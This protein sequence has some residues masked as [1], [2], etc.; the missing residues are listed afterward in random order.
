[1]ELSFKELICGL[2]YYLNQE[3]Q[4][5]D[6]HDLS[7]LWNE[8]VRLDK[9]TY[10]DE[11][12]YEKLFEPVEKLMKEFNDI[13][14]KSMAFRYPVGK[15]QERKTSHN[16]KSLDLEN[17]RNVFNKLNNFIEMHD[18]HVYNLIDQKEEYDAIMRSDMGYG[19]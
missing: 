13:D 17:F 19:Y 15:G 16:T 10:K 4:F 12:L 3:Y 18:A 2:N 5:S 8:F 6:G 11:A 1:M 14:P 9:Q 7:K